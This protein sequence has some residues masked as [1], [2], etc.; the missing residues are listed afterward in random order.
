MNSSYPVTVLTSDGGQPLRDIIQISV[1]SQHN[2][3]LTSEGEVK[4]WGLGYGGGAG[5]WE[6]GRFQLPGHCIGG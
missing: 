4:C 6:H 1:G 5:E 2:C 3:A